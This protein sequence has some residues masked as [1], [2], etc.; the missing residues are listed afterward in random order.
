MHDITSE[1]GAIG[2][3]QSFIHRLRQKGV[4]LWMEGSGL[5]YRAPKGVLTAEDRQTLKSANEVIA[6]HVQRRG[7][8]VDQ[9]ADVWRAPFSFTQL[10]G[11]HGHIRRGGRPIRNIASAFRLRGALEVDLLKECIRTIGRRHDALRTRI[12]LCEGIAPFQ[13]V[14]ERYRS[15]LE[16]I[17]LKSVP[18]D[19]KEAQVQAHIEHA[20]LDSRSYAESPLFKAVLLTIDTSEH[21]LIFALDHL[22]CDRASLNHTR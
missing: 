22:V 14:A 10:R 18:D 19:Q 7:G 17:P 3:P 11:L 9:S 1:L 2:D 12:V 8:L 5:R 20:I 6:L 16:V 13:E 15:D 4:V 21:V